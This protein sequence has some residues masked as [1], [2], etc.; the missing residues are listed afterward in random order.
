MTGRNTDPRRLTDEMLGYCSTI[1]RWV[2]K[3][4]AAFLD[5]ETGSQ[6][7]IERQFEQFEEAAN[8]LGKPFQKANPGIP[9]TPIFDIRNDFTHP[10]QRTYD[11]EKLWRFVRGDLPRITQRLKRPVF[12]PRRSDLLRE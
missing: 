9:W 11:P 3:G 4:H 1:A 8:A 10:Y 7:T 6:A 5:P 12:P 2:A